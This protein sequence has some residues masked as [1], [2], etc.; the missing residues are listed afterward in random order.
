[1]SKTHENIFKAHVHHFQKYHEHLE[2]IK[3]F[4]S[5]RIMLLNVL[6]VFYMLWLEK[7]YE[8]HEHFLHFSEYFK[9]QK[10]KAC[11][12]YAGCG[13]RGRSKSHD[14]PGH[15]ISSSTLLRFSKCKKKKDSNGQK[16]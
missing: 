3:G 13:R 5:V 15:W 2:K 9:N 10:K 6:N 1:M 12:A 14:R 4:L 16:F 7:M 8:F 11:D